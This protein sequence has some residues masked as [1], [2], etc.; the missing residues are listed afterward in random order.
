MV[1]SKRCP[2][3][4]S[5][6]SPASSWP[7]PQHGAPDLKA[8]DL[9][10]ENLECLDLVPMV[11]RIK[12]CEKPS[13]FR[14]PL[15]FYYLTSLLMIPHRSRQIENRPGHVSPPCPQG[16]VQVLGD[17]TR[18]SNVWSSQ[19]TKSV[20]SSSLCAHPSTRAHQLSTNSTA[21]GGS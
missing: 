8:C 4:C 19:D 6:I 5:T 3:L 18:C 9:S 10:F 14:S 13:S 7:S 16:F 20:Y 15:F 1:T 17:H 21:F 11:S 12:M 2:Y